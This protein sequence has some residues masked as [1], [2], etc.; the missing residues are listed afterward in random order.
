MPSKQMRDAALKRISETNLTLF[1][2]A[3]AIKIKPGKSRKQMHRNWA[4]NKAH[5]FIKAAP[6]AKEKTIRIHYQ[7]SGNRD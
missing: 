4:V 3:I 1:D 7:V 5:D 6:Q 2:N